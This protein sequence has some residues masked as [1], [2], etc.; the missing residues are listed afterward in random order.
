MRF[1]VG[2]AAPANARRMFFFLERTRMQSTFI[3]Y[4]NAVR[5]TRGNSACALTSSFFEMAHKPRMTP[6]RVVRGRTR[7]WC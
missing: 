7:F 5:R 6:R 2:G 1:M 4:S 3:R